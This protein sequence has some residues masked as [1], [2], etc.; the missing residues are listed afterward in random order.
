[1][2]LGAFGW[3][4][5]IPRSANENREA[6][7]RPFVIL[8][9]RS[10]QFIGVYGRSEPRGER[11]VPVSE[12]SVVGKRWGLSNE[13]YFEAEISLLRPEHEFEPNGFFLTEPEDLEDPDALEE[14]DL[15]IE[16]R[17]LLGG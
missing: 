4:L 7:R 10:G 14:Y 2:K 1:M 16:F 8:M 9:E 17:G 13:T 3:A 11:F 15:W 6:K 12:A 5:H